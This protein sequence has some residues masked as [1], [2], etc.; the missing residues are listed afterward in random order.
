M[1]GGIDAVEG[2]VSDGLLACVDGGAIA[3]EAGVD[4]LLSFLEA[5]FSTGNSGVCF[6]VG[7]A[8]G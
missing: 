7:T 4:G 5:V 8:C 2:S 3:L 6:V 1:V